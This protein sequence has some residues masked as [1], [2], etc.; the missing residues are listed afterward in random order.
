MHQKRYDSSHMLQIH[1]ITLQL[2]KNGASSYFY[3]FNNINYTNLRSL[4]PNFRFFWCSPTRSL[5][6]MAYY[7]GIYMYIYIYFQLPRLFAGFQDD[8]KMAISAWRKRQGLVANLNLNWR[9]KMWRTKSSCMLKN[10]ENNCHIDWNEDCILKTVEGLRF[11]GPCLKCEKVTSKRWCRE[12]HYHITACCI[13]NVPL[14]LKRKKTRL[15][16]DWKRLEWPSRC[17]IWGFVWPVFI[18]W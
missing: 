12:P 1:C 14:K 3:N 9:M 8:L 6:G 7:V 5:F 4:I 2:G 11:E 17:L 10:E 13:K 18:N 15:K 16:L